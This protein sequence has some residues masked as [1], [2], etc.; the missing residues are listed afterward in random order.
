M[1]DVSE[2][3]MVLKKMLMLR[4]L[5]IMMSSCGWNRFDI[6]EGVFFV[7]LWLV[8]IWCLLG[9]N[10]NVLMKSMVRIVVFISGV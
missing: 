4:M 6:V 2:V 7:V 1:K 8:E 3:S 10:V 5:R 9:C